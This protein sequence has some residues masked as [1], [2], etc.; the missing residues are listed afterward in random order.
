MNIITCYSLIALEIDLHSYKYLY[1]ATL[2]GNNT[3]IVFFFYFFVLLVKVLIQMTVISDNYV[4]MFFIA[5]C[6]VRVLTYRKLAHAIKCVAP[7]SSTVPIVILRSR[8]MT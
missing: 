4:L 8:M 7:Q 6:Y 5:D 3:E 1:L 2:G